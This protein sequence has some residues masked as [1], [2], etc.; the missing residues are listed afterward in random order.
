M[1][2][3]GT[4]ATLMGDLWHMPDGNKF[5]DKNML[6]ERK[7]ILCL[8]MQQYVSTDVQPVH[9]VGRYSQEQNTSNSGLLCSIPV[10][11]LRYRQLS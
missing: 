5:S 4:T 3:M 7:D 8:L 6:G 10:I 9:E 2:S 11:I 1:I